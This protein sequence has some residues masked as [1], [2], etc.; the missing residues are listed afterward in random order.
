VREL[1]ALVRMPAEPQTAEHG[2]KH[3]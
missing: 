2:E 1:A 3:E